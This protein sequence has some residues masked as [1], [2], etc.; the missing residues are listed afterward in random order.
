MC[1]K[2][3]TLT[4]RDMHCTACVM[5]LEGIKDDLPGIASIRASYLKQTL[6]IEYEEDKVGEIEIRQAVADLGYT[7]EK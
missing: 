3:L 5:R 7:V 1:M 2:Q 4:I 6:V